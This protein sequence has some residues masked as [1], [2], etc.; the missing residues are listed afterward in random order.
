LDVDEAWEVVCAAHT[1]IFTSLR[2]DGTPIALPVWFVVVDRVVWLS[3]P[4]SSKKVARVRRN[5][6]TSFLVESGMRWAELKAV[7]LT[8]SATVVEGESVNRV[9]TEKGRKYASHQS[10]RSKMPDRTRDY[11]SASRVAIR[12]DPDERILSWDNSRLDIG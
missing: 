3:T 2:R 5:P 4:A 11:Y 9:D 10:A 12:L 8:C 1:G 7:H 6:R